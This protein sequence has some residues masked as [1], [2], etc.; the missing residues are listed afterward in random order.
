MNNHYYFLNADPEHYRAILSLFQSADELFLIYPSATWP[1]DLTQLEKLAQQRTD[2]TV[3]VDD[4][5]VIGFANLYRNLSADKIFVGNVVISQSYRGKGVGRQ[6][7]CHMCDLVFD[8]YAS[9]VHITVFN[10]NTPAL[11]LYRSLGFKPYDME[12]RH[13]PNGQPIMAIHMQLNR[14]SW[15]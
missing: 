14:R 12:V 15:R 6:L 11:V 3:V 8:N 7:V 1:F 5:Q 2:L 10:P 13:T 4:D 9:E